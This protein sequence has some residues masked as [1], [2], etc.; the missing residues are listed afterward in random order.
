MTEKEIQEMRGEINAC[1]IL[2][3]DT[4]YQ[5]IKHADGVISDEDYEEMRSKRQAWRNRINELEE[6]ISSATALEEPGEA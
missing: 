6:T 5:S 2:L 3:R 1:K 4:D